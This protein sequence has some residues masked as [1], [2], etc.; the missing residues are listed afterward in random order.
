MARRYGLTEKQKEVVSKSRAVNARQE[1]PKQ[2]DHYQLIDVPRLLHFV[3][4]D[5]F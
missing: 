2:S 4:N 1:L 3:R 5:D